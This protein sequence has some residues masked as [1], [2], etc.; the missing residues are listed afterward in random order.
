MSNGLHQEALEGVSSICYS[1]PTPPSH[2]FLSR[3]TF[4]PKTNKIWKTEVRPGRSFF[5]GSIKKFCFRIGL[6]RINFFS[7]VIK[8]RCR[9]FVPRPTGW[10]FRV[11]SEKNGAKGRK[12]DQEN[13]VIRLLFSKRFLCGYKLEY[14]TA[15]FIITLA[16][17]IHFRTRPT[18]SW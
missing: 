8:F 12:E 9:N 1:P 13:S 10:V 4:E 14:V 15:A 6:E 11:W 18:V 16:C 5:V 3:P 2:N 17:S 7:G